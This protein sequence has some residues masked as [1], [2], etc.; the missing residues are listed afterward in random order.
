MFNDILFLQ[1]SAN[2]L[3]YEVL[4]QIEKIFMNEGMPSSWNETCKLTFRNNIFTKV[5]EFEKCLPADAADLSDR[6]LVTHFD[7]LQKILKEKN[8]SFCAWEAIRANVRSHLIQ[9]HSVAK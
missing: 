5:Q 6:R 3:I 9:L 7:G 8:Y 1:T 4:L 2:A